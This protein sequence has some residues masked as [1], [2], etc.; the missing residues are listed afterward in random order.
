[1]TQNARDACDGAAELADCAFDQKVGTCS[2]GVCIEALCGDGVKSGTEQCDKADFGGVS[3]DDLEFYDDGPLGCSDHCEYI[4]DACPQRRCGDGIKDPE[5]RCDSTPDAAADDC[6]EVGYYRS[7]PVKCNASCEF[8]YSACQDKG[9]CG[10]GTVDPEESCD[11]TVPVETC[12]DGGYDAGRMGCTKFCTPSYVECKYIGWKRALPG[13]QDSYADIIVSSAG[14]YILATGNGLRKVVNNAAMGVMIPSQT[15]INSLW[16]VGADMWLAGER[17][18]IAKYDGTTVTLKQ[19]PSATTLDSLY[20]VFAS[21]ATD[22]YA[23]GV[24]RIVHDT[25]ANTWPTEYSNADYFYQSMWGTSTGSDVFAVGYAQ[26]GNTYVI[27]HKASAWSNESIAGISVSGMSLSAVWGFDTSPATVT[28]VGYP[29]RVLRRNSSNGSWNTEQYEVAAV[30]SI[31]LHGVWGR[32]PNELFVVGGVGEI[33]YFDGT[34]WRLLTGIT[35]PLTGIDGTATDAYAIGGDNVYRDTH[36]SWS[37]PVPNVGNSAVA[38]WTTAGNK[39]YLLTH[40]VLQVKV[41]PAFTPFSPAIPTAFGNPGAAGMWQGGST[42]AVISNDI[43]TGSTPVSSMVHR[44][45]GSSWTTDTFPAAAIGTDLTCI[46]G[47]SALLLV[48][49]ADGAIRRYSGSW[50]VEAPA[51]AG[52]R[53]NAIWSDASGVAYAA[54][55]GPGGS[56]GPAGE[57][58][59]RDAT[60]TWTAMTLPAGVGGLDSVWGSSVNDVFI[61]GGPGPNNVYHYDGTSWTRM[62]TPS[63]Y[64]LKEIAGTVPAVAGTPSKDVFAVGSNGSVL[65]YDG[66]YWTQLRVPEA[67][68]GAYEGLSVRTGLVLISGSL[69]GPSSSFALVRTGDW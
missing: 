6:T 57:V 47:T 45:N 1:V 42:I 8:D 65:H 19:A 2:L 30:P 52:H 40:D 66:T 61:T 17:G 26:S 16:K 60:G 48:G 9:F 59:R 36:A 3:C 37:L 7:G 18:Y 49:S 55:Y 67:L 54:G 22:V 44:F 41:G 27:S 15:A 51:A 21:S 14:N 5:E 63:P 25:G 68:V 23:A 33:G 24:N 46:T 34:W 29:S 13:Q 38:V 56:A 62:M 10:D 31:D 20:G 58:R 43:T 69:S 32:S 53:V 50:S 64:D 11:A 12:V 35:T 39:T 4:K 28:A